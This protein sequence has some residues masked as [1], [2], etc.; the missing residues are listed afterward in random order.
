MPG[1]FVSAELRDD[2]A[3][4]LDQLLTLIGSRREQPAEQ[5]DWIPHEPERDRRG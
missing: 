4:F 2:C 3:R 5:D 1:E